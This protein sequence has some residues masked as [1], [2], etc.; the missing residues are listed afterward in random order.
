METH[1]QTSTQHLGEMDADSGVL[2][3]Q[4]SQCQE[5]FA[6]KNRRKSSELLEQA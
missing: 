4:L 2:S 1:K 6:L 5:V 3:A